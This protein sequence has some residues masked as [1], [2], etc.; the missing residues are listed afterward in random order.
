MP[1]FAGE[2]LGREEK[3]NRINLWTD[4]NKNLNWR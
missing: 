4:E 3:K 2:H 1:F